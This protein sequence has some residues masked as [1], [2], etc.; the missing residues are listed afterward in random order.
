MTNDKFAK[1]LVSLCEILKRFTNPVSYGH[2]SFNS[3][4]HRRNCFKNSKIFQLN[5]KLKPCLVGGCLECVANGKIQEKKIFDNIWIQ[6]AAGD[7][8]LRQ[9]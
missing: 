4:S 1:L 7:G 9:H 8:G 5:I 3:E 6:P 2:C